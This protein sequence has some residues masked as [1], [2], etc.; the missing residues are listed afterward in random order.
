M[1]FLCRLRAFR[2]V[3]PALDFNDRIWISAR[4]VAAIVILSFGNR[5]PYFRISSRHRFP[6]FDRARR[7]RRQVQ[8]VLLPNV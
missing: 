1:T 4:R 2:F 6:A 8:Y 3:Y 7:T 5:L